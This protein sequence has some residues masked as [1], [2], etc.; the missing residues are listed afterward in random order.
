MKDA[1]NDDTVRTKEEEEAGGDPRTEASDEAQEPQNQNDGNG[2]DN[3]S[4]ADINEDFEDL[5]E[6]NTGMDVRQEQPSVPEDQEQEE[7]MD[8]GD[9]LN[10]EDDD[11][12]E[13]GDE[14][15]MEEGG[16]NEEDNEDTEP[17]TDEATEKDN[18]EQAAESDNEQ[19]EGHAADTAFPD[20]NENENP[21]KES[22]ANEEH[23]PPRID[24]PPESSTE[25]EGLGISA[26]DG[27]DACQYTETEEEGD[28]GP[29]DQEDEEAGVGEDVEE[30]NK[31]SGGQGGSGDG[32][33]GED[34]R[35]DGVTENETKACSEEVPNPF[36]NPGDATK[37]WHKKLHMVDSQNLEEETT[38]TGE[39]TAQQEENIAGEFEY[40]PE[41]MAGTSQV[42]GEVAEEEAVDLEHQSEPNPAVSEVEQPRQE[43]RVE[44]KSARRVPQKSPKD[45][46]A[47][48]KI[49]VEK[50]DG[51]EVEDE[52]ID[53]VGSQ[54]SGSHSSSNNNDQESV[55]SDEDRPS[56]QV[57]SDMSRLDIEEE[58]LSGERMDLSFVEDEQVSG[59]SS[60]EVTEARHRWLRIVGDTHNLA[61]RLC[62]KLRLVMEPLVAS[63]LK[64]DYRTGKRI[65]MKRV[66]GYV[67]SGY[68]KDKIWLRRTKPAKRNY[69]VLLAVDDSESMIKGGTGEMALRAMA[70]LARGMSQL[71]IGELG[72]AS[73]GD[74]MKL[75]HPFN[76][77]FTSESGFDVVKKIRFDQART[78][79][80][81]CL[82]SALSVLDTPGDVA[83][84]QIVFLI[85][86]GRIERNSR[87]TLKKLIREMM[88][89]N[90]LLAMI[91]VE[92]PGDDKRK[93][94]SIV[95]MKEV[96]FEKG[97]P[98]V[99]RFMEDY[100]FPYYLFLDDMQ[101]LPEVLGDALR[102]WFEMLAQLQ[103]KR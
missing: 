80:S 74:D 46:T 82:Q 8:L 84:L 87:S 27:K 66:I 25:H 71:E 51:P 29:A 78:R 30:K 41:Q 35:Q 56:N 39:S 19:D 34:G 9:D 3:G 1:K 53:D 36:K 32:Q 64:G 60:A 38:E 94:D 54:H 69:R 93:G 90:I 18:Q 37:F 63:K 10:L 83:S 85:S 58:G 17:L 7:S 42:L 92:P 100:P 77:P 20:P 59:I 15:P 99:K 62:E 70:T 5:Y 72:V 57:V 97:K 14:N 48:N 91:I 73:F 68:R 103:D 43:S 21:E 2:S 95:N 33:Q 24:L 79:T 75:L 45:Q 55:A 23:E 89:R 50:D 76:K 40:A 12:G 98:I 52:D 31:P 28:A 102:Q 47:D 65:S 16:F 26:P 22:E 81:L 67:A 4:E 86:D 11:N 6:E 13:G 44:Q 96:T 101:A 88:E 61:L 49:K